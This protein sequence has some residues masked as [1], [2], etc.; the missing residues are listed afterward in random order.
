MGTGGGGETRHN[1]LVVC[2]SLV[3]EGVKA[4]PAGRCGDCEARVVSEVTVETTIAR[5]RLAGVVPPA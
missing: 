4:V 2:A 3:T 5:G 1:G